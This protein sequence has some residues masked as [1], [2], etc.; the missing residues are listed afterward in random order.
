VLQVKDD[1]GNPSQR[2]YKM[3]TPIVRR[4]LPPG[5]AKE[6]VAPRKKVRHH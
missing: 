2:K 6:S 5:E 3:N 1:S 4:V